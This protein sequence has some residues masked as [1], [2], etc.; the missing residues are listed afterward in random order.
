MSLR[1]LAVGSS[2]PGVVRSHNEDSG[3]ISPR[4]LAVADGMGGHAAGEIAS[5]TI[6]RELAAVAIKGAFGDNSL[7]RAIERT[8]VALADL[9]KSDQSRAG[10]GTTVSAVAITENKIVVVHVGDSR[11]YR[12]HNGSLMS[13]TRDHTY[14]QTL[15]DVGEIS[16]AEAK[17]HPKRSLLTQ[18]VDAQSNISPD[19][20]EVEVEPGDRLLVCSDGL[21]GLVEP[22]V[23]LRALQKD[24]DSAVND[25]VAAAQAAGAP[26][27]VTV[28]V[29]DIVSTTQAAD[30]RGV[31]VIGA[32]AEGAQTVKVPRH[33]GFNPIV[34]GM[35]SVLLVATTVFGVQRW[36]SGQWQVA[37][38]DG[39][40]VVNQGIAQEVFGFKLYRTKLVSRIPTT[41]LPL[42]EQQQLERGV[43]VESL[44]QASET[45]VQLAQR[46]STCADNPSICLP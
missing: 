32:A 29:A 20:T 26:D 40:V 17:V 4:L 1:F 6:I 46:S 28:I 16:E 45:L 13:L 24:R 23:M 21:S 14:V 36:W 12:Y 42:F 44:D 15:L 9:S 22:D 2:D 38:Q 19:V 37:N 25:L 31:T 30:A 8:K 43:I 18:A 34:V 11:V 39:V 33:F 10:L 7:V 35:I 41:S 5:T 3:L 27:N